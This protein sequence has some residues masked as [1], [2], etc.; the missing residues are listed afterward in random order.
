MEEIAA[1]LTWTLIKDVDL[2]RIALAIGLDVD[3][4]LTRMVNI[5]VI[6]FSVARSGGIRQISII[7][8]RC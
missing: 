5:R 2:E 8:H 7:Y 6:T 4:P 3:I 1:Y